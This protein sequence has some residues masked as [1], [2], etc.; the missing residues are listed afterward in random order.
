[1]SVF[2]RSQQKWIRE[3][4][5]IAVVHGGEKS[6]PENF[7][8]ENLSPRSTKTYQPVA[9]DIADALCESGFKHVCVLPENIDLPRRLKELNIDLVVTNSGGLQGFDS[10]CHLPSMLEMLGV[11]YVGHSPMTA[12]V[13]DNKHLFKHEINAAGIPTAPFITVALGEDIQSIANQQK[14][15][16]MEAEFGSAFVVK[17]VSGRASV[18]VYP[19]F[20]REQLKHK[21]EHVQAATNNTVMIEPFLSGREFVVAVAGPVV[22]KNDELSKR[23]EPL[24]FSITERVLLEDEP[25]FTSMD[26]KPITDDRLLK[27]ED[28]ELRKQLADLGIKIFKQL[29][30]HTLVRVDLRMD[31]QGQLYVLETN[32][33]PDLKRPEGNKLSIVCHDIQGE[34]MTYHDLIQSLVFNRLVYLNNTRPGALSHCLNDEFASLESA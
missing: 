11:P 19:V 28:P 17:P 23:E 32:P 31:N 3:F 21:I 4:L 26:V 14:L 10:M 29:G 30:L 8:Y 2:S 20:D 34:G 1:M 16:S 13:L 22:F 27:V 15:D 6:Q 7:I 5:S 12:G 33:K 18:H 25:I 9:C 24:A